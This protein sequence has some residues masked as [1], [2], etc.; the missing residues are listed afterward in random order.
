MESSR[1]SSKNRP[2]EAKRGGEPASITPLVPL[3][4]LQTMRHKDRPEEVL[5]EEDISVSL[6]R[7]LGLSEVVRV[8]I[9]RFEEEVK[10]RRPQRA[11]QVEDLVRLVIR[12]PDSEEIFFDT[13]RHVAER[14][15]DER[16]QWMR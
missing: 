5:E 16:S 13:G 14:F 10:Q 9:H 11:S 3:L 15:W 1:R 7:R 2:Q 4:L 8:Q 6:P 12:R